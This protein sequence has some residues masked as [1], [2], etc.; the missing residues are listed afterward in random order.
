[1]YVEKQ[2]FLRLVSDITRGVSG[3]LSRT[4]LYVTATAPPHMENKLPHGHI[5][6]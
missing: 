4:S 6:S 5:N 2:T 3:S 1:M